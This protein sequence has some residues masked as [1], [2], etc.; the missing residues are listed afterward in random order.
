MAEIQIKVEPTA[1]KQEAEQIRGIISKLQNEYSGLCAVVNASSGYWEGDAANAYRTYIKKLDD[2]MQTVL[3]R[4]SEHPD[5]LLKMAGLYDEAEVKATEVA[6]SLSSN[7][8]S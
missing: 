2:N 5:D 4:L 6:A 8:I 7:V 1:M 3:K